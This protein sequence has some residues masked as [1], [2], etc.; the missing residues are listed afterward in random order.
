MNRK[1]KLRHDIKV[2]G[3][4][5]RRIED[6]EYAEERKLY[7]GRCYKFLN[8]YDHEGEKWW[9]YSRVDKTG[10]TKFEF[11][12]DCFG[13]VTIQ[14]DHFFLGPLEDS[15]EIT[16]EECENEWDSLMES[17]DSQWECF[18]GR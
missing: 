17:L 7:A 6:Q 1:E 4:E 5:L 3:D 16:P 14:A 2:L 11:E 8:S 10:E 15:I 9:S 18:D 13:Q 12:R